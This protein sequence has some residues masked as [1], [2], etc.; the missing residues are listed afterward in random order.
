MKYRIAYIDE[1]K[2]W[3]NTF[4][5]TFKNDFD[6][7]RIEVNPESSVESILNQLLESDLNAIVT[8]YL[9]EEKQFATPLIKKIFLN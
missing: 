8:D 5:Q 6:I 3:I 7:L 1:D 4:Y 2:G 9:L